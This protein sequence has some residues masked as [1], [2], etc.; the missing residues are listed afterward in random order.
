MKTFFKKFFL[1]TWGVMFFLCIATTKWETLP[2][3]LSLIGALLG[4]VFACAV[5]AAICAVPATLI[6]AY[7]AF[8]H[9][10]THPLYI[11]VFGPRRKRWLPARD[12]KRE[13]VAEN[14]PED[15]TL[16]WL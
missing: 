12:E 10:P 7:A 14:D 1:T 2:P 15:P 13:A 9:K 4:I 5:L 3:D 8:C 16:P 6:F 11:R